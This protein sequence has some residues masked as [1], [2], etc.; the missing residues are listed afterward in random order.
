MVDRM[1][2]K[3]WKAQKNSLQERVQCILLWH[4]LVDLTIEKGE[5]EKEIVEKYSR[6]EGVQCILLWHF[7]V[8][9][10]SEKGENQ[11]GRLEKQLPT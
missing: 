5:N 10:T 6:Q 3:R 2:E 9:E 1:S 11:M 8:D 4:F 7:L